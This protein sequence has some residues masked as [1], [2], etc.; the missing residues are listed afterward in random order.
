MHTQ[1]KRFGK[2]YLA[3][4]IAVVSLTALTVNAQEIKKSLDKVVVSAAGFEQKI[5]DAPASVTVVSREELESRPYTSLPDALRDVEGID[6]GSSFDKNGNISI[7]MRGMASKY[8]LVLIDGKRQSDVGELGPNNFGNAQYMYMPP[9]AAI[10]RVEIIRG[11]MSTLY[12]ADAMGGV[13]NIITR[14]VAKEWSGSITTGLTFQ[15]N[16]QFGD[17]KKVDFYTSGPLVEGLL[18]LTVRGSI[19]D[20]EESDPGYPTTQ[21]PLP[22]VDKNGEPNDPYW[23][24]AATFGDRKIVS[25]RNW[26]MGGTLAYTPHDKHTFELSYDVSKQKY[27]NTQGQT[28]TLDGIDSLWR[29]GANG[30]VTP[31]VGYTEYQRFERE[32]VSLTHVGELDFGRWETSLTHNTSENL[33]RSLPLTIQERDRLQEIW[34]DNCAVLRDCRASG[35]VFILPSKSVQDE[36]AAEFL[37]RPNREIGIDSYTL[38]TKLD[39][40]IGESHAITLGAQYYDADMTDGVFG[41]DGAG[42]DKNAKAKHRQIA[43]F[44][45][46][47]WALND[48]LVATLGARFDDHNIFGDHL[49]PRVYLTW[50][51]SE[52]LT[53]KGGVSTGYKTPEPNQLFSGITGF[54]GQG[55]NPMVGNPDL[56]PEESIN[57]EAAIYFDNLQGFTA[58]ATVFY[59]DFK[60]RIANQSSA[61]NCYNVNDEKVLTEDC[62]DIGPGWAGYGF[63]SFSQSINIDKAR[64]QGIELA[65]R[66]EITPAWVI[67]GNYTFT[68]SEQ[69]SGDEKGLPLVDTPEHMFNA[70]LEWQVSDRFNMH[71]T[72]EVR[73]K[74]FDNLYTNADSVE[75]KR[76]FKAYEVFHLGASFKASDTLTLNARI[77]NVFDKDLSTYSYVLNDAQNGYSRLADYPTTAASRSFW[78]SANMV[79]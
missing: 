71:L 51:A 28:G 50:T 12:G 18:G 70:T 75:Y 76:Y 32:Q 56:K 21:L 73:S 38:D 16:S 17:D 27:D 77:N 44:A 2:S 9:L 14:K 62:V 53:L 65:S 15:E 10:E 49:S 6:V 30:K 59:N 64:T 22:S 5:T 13:I 60:D 8:T 54:G 67:R 48:S 7:T 42:F 41:M 55:V 25:A 35:S 79:F 37:P 58:N 45:E 3:S 57:Y 74:R 61:Q 52:N 26:N 66:Y 24:A 4:A 29:A 1:K 69:T 34:D 46:D 23:T 11:P 68:D 72:S 78:L 19:Y 33:G 39:T 40:S 20:R 63:N 47:H 43:I 36:I 31:R